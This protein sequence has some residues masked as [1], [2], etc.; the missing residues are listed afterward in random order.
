MNTYI[1]ESRGLRAEHPFILL[2][3]HKN[4]EY[5]H[6]ARHLNTHQAGWSLF[7]N[8]FLFSS[9]LLPWVQKTQSRCPV[10]TIQP[11]PLLPP[12]SL[13]AIIHLD[14]KRVEL[15]LQDEPAPSACPNSL[16][17]ILNICP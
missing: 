5:L 16:L 14:I 15:V 4:L 12:S 2:P 17:L 10:L 13:L 6:S 8:G 3:Y 7:F 1:S 9:V 11:Q